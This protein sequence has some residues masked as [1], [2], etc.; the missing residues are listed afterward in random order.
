M[1]CGGLSQPRV[2][3]DSPAPRARELRAKRSALPLSEAKLM[4][5]RVQPGVVRRPR[6]FRALERGRAAALTLID[7]PVGYGKTM[8]MRSWCSEHPTPVAWIT[9]DEGDAD[10][11]RLWTYV[12]SAVERVAEGL[13]RPVLR[14]L[15]VPGA[16]IEPSVDQLLN[17]LHTYA[18]PLAIVLDDLHLLGEPSFR[19]IGYALER[20]PEN[21]RVLATTR[22]DPPIRL[23]RLRA[24]GGLSEI[25]ARELAFTVAEGRECS[26]VARGSS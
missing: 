14:R 25:R 23:A 11:V 20:L 3:D 12:A 6:L 22:S 13:G 8:L 19:S 17:G 10:P 24:R 26:S 9:L 7:A 15:A 5:P 4:L 18:R 21:V 16:P 2:G 1:I